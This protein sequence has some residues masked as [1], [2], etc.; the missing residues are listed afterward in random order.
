MTLLDWLAIWCVASVVL[1][2][3]LG[4]VIGTADLHDEDGPA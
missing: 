4:S 1:G 3:I 2:V